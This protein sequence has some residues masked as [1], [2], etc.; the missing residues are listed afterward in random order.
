MDKPFDRICVMGLGYIGLPTAATLASRGV[1]VIGVDVNESVVAKISEGQS[2]FSEPDLD[3]LVRSAVSTERLRA[4]SEPEPADA[5]LVAVPTP[6]RADHNADLSCVEAAARAIAR[7]LEP[8]NLVILESTCPVGTTLRFC[9]W[10]AEESPDLRL[11]HEE[12]AN[13]DINVT[14]CPERILPGRMILELVENDRIIGGMTE[15][16]AR[17]AEELYEIFVKGTLH[18]SNASTA[19]LVKLTENAY[20]DVN[21]AFANELS[22]VCEKLDVDVW[23]AIDLANRHPRVNILKPGPGVGGHCIAIDPWFLIANA[24]EETRLMQAA[25]RVNDV[26]SHAVLERVRRQMRRFREPVVACLGLSYKPDVDDLRESPALHIVEE[27][28]RDDEMQLL[29]VEPHL[30]TLPATLAEAIHVEKVEMNDALSRADIL[31]LLVG[32]R[33][34]RK[35]DMRKIYERVVI[36]TV[37]LWR[38]DRGEPR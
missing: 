23:E 19:E 17:R 21:I 36:D 35:V 31:V 25:R 16:C 11:P 32:H 37:G 2:H 4:V 9:E 10:I 33:E 27:L 14:Y 28:A 6:F 30:K 22:M 3:M 38:V 7:V 20:R 15:T 29:V 13:P 34:F 12:P 1:D 5:F 24:P 8:G 18:V 26:K